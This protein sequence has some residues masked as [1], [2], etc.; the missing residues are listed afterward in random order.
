MA[1][2][3]YHITHVGNLPLIIASG[4]L[5]CRNELKAR[6]LAPAFDI[7]MNEIQDRR[8]SVSVVGM[9]LTL[10]DY[11]PFAFRPNPPMLYQV[12]EGR[13]INYKGGPAKI[14]HLE[15]SAEDV[16]DLNLRFAIAVKH[17]LRIHRT[18]DWYCSLASLDRLDW[19]AI[20]APYMSKTD[21]RWPYRQAEFLV[22][23]RVPWDL[24]RQI[25]VSDKVAE[26][27]VVEC[28]RTSKHTPSVAIRPEWYP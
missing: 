12:A 9:D 15:L 8:D 13:G 20:E 21:P 19:E 10:H 18:R 11:V 24:V 6:H 3:V 2:P 16:D 23:T 26:A 17:P 14:V 25:G 5:L 1:T 27:E 7:S 4:A 22:K 28:L